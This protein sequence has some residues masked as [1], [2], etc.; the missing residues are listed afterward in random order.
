MDGIVV[1]VIN[2]REDSFIIFDK[3]RGLTRQQY[4]SVCNFFDEVVLLCSNNT[5]FRLLVTGKNRDTVIKLI[6]GKYKSIVIDSNNDI[7]FIGAKARLLGTDCIKPGDIFS[8]IDNLSSDLSY[9]YKAQRGSDNSFIAFIYDRLS[10]DERLELYDSEYINIIRT[11]KYLLSIKP[12]NIRQFNG[13]FENSI[14]M[15]VTFTDIYMSIR[16]KVSSIFGYSYKYFDLTVFNGG[17][18]AWVYS[19]KEYYG[20]GVSDYD[21]NL[22]N[23]SV[24]YCFRNFGSGVIDDLRDINCNEIKEEIKIIRV[25]PN[26]KYTWY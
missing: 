1:D 7:V 23:K 13:V 18:R 19:Y 25:Y 4:N 22:D 5:T 21:N 26:G 12:K 2:G 8:T 3:Q 24:I 11:V 14:G 17:F 10:N 20:I 16:E 15:R 9:N 6:K